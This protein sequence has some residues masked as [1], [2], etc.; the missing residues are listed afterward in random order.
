MTNLNVKRSVQENASRHNV[1]Q[2]KNEIHIFYNFYY[3]YLFIIYEKIRYHI[4]NF[5]Y[6]FLFLLCSLDHYHSNY[7]NLINFIIYISL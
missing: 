7:H 6:S 1:L 2:D 4:Y 5:N 3:N